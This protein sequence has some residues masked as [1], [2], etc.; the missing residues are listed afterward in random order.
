M[1]AVGIVGIGTMGSRFGAKLAESGFKVFG[2]DSLPDN[3][4]RNRAANIVRRDSLAELAGEA[5]RIVLFLPGPAEIRASVLGPD[6]LLAHLPKGGVIVD[7]CTSDPDNTMDM[8]AAAAQAGVRYLDAPVLGRP[9]SIGKWGL[10]VGGE[11]ETLEECL[12]FLRPVAEQIVHIGPSGS[13]HKVKLLNQLM[14][15][16]INAM[17]AEMMALAE[18]TGIAPAK[19]SEIIVGSHA[20]TVSGLFRELGARV[21]SGHYRDP[22]FTV[23]LLNKDVRL[24]ME[25]A[26]KAGAALVV[27]SAVDHLNRLAMAQGQGKLDTAIMWECVKRRWRDH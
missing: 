21:A 2:Y 25:M 19:L 15:G 3:A 20:S 16:A 18:K 13:G 17:T 7:M 27:G 1:A 8:A 9:D 22:A 23:A 24:G 5:G 11:A 12:E 6:G 10:P 4:E 26:E 14:F